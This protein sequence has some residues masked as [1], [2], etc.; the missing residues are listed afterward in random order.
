MKHILT[1]M[2]VLT[3]T[4]IKVVGNVFS[5]LKETVAGIVMMIVY[6]GTIEGTPITNVEF[7]NVLITVGMFIIIWYGVIK[8]FANVIWKFLFGK[9][10]E[11]KVGVLEILFRKLK[12]VY[13]QKVASMTDEELEETTDTY[14][15]KLHKLRQKITKDNTRRCCG[16]EK[17]K[18]FAK[19]VLKNYTQTRKQTLQLGLWVQW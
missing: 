14:V 4:F 7:I 12:P 8:I 18:A 3:R 2:L 5:D 19:S 16:L 11:W 6:K 9:Q 13:L 1:S 17:I 15:Q 10:L